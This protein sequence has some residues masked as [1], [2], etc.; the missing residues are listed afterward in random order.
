M[1]EH[2]TGV[3]Y[4]EF[5]Y[6]QPVRLRI[7]RETH[8]RFS[9][10]SGDGFLRWVISRLGA[11]AGDLVLDAGCGPGIYHPFLHQRGARIVALD[12]SLGMVRAA[13]DSASER[14]RPIQACRARLE[15]L[16]LASSS[17]DRAMAN[18]VLYHVPDIKR[19]LLELRRVL[20]PAGRIVMATGARNYCQD[21]RDLHAKAARKLG[22]KPSGS[23]LARF[24][25]DHLE[26][27]RQVFP[28]VEVFEFED[29]FRFPTTGPALRYYA[30]GMVDGI[31]NAPPDGR[32]RQPL[33]SEMQK[34]L[35]RIIQREGELVIPKSSALFVADK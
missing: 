7:R 18:H 12:Y 31:E 19:A 14:R 35:R 1:T 30:T 6:S 10:K 5:Q 34:S 25:P 22:Y 3:D 33:I 4:L 32:H 20:K 23:I 9:D 8:A 17:C 24:S 16:P 28:S 15:S 27:V 29:A 11:E 13:L 26:L 2:G 21:L